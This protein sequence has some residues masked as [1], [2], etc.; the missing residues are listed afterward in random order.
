[1]KIKIFIT[2]DH[3][4]VRKGIAAIL[5]NETDIHVVGDSGSGRETIRQLTDHDVDILLLDISLPDMN[6]MDVLERIQVE[7]P[8]L[9]VVIFTMF[10]EDSLATR[11]LNAGA[12]GYLTKEMSHEQII[13]AI[14]QVAKGN[15][16][17]APT[18]AV[19]LQAK[20]Q[21]MPHESLTNREFTIFLKIAE[22]FPLHAIAD[23]LHLAPSTVSTY[24]LRILEKMGMTTNADLVRYAT[25]HQQIV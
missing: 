15:Q 16:Y 3:F 17:V 18:L 21:V 13:D 6:G 7:R 24:R 20:S 10:A 12:Y 2:D 9:R 8:Q 14:R 23:E 11:F 19:K 22:G 1:M 5:A 25:Q 4:V